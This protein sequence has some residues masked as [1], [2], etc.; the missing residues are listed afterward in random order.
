M[1]FADE[2]CVAPDDEESNYRLAAETL[3]EPAAIAPARV[4]RMHGELGPAP[5]AARYAEEL[6]TQLPA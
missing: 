4:H 6:R 1:W 5:G 3:L 2:R